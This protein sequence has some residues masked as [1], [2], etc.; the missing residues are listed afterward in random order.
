MY[1]RLDGVTGRA[2][3]ASSVS[4]DLILSKAHSPRRGCVRCVKVLRPIDLN[5]WHGRTVGYH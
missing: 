3:L 5:Q 2:D 1:L 4:C